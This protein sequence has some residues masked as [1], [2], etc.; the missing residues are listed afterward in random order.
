MEKATG[1]RVP[2]SHFQGTRAISTIFGSAGLA[3]GHGCCFPHWYGVGD[4]RVMVLELTAK[5]LFG[6]NYPSIASPG[7]RRLNFRI[8]Q[9]K[10]K[11]CKHLQELVNKHNLQSRL[12]AIQR[13]PTDLLVS[14]L[15][16]LH[17]KLDNELG[18]YMRSAEKSCTKY[19]NDHIDYSPTVGQWLKRR[20]ILKWIL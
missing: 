1:E 8:R 17:N 14:R 11:Y 20:A 3:Y 10:L 4:H 13:P 5:S 2:N 12:E 16:H 6:G 18:D 9:T 19:K 7:A 15:H